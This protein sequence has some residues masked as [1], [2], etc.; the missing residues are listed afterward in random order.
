MI[1]LAVSNQKGGVGKTTTCINLAAELGRK[2]Y[3]V[4]SVDIDPQA[5][6]TS[7]LGVALPPDSPSLYNVLLGDVPPP[8]AILQTKWRGVSIL[9]ATLDLAGAEI[10]LA[11]SISRET[12][13]RR[14]LSRIEG[15]DIAIL[16]CP[17]SLGMLTVNALV[18]A[19]KLVIPIQCEYFALE[20]LGQLSRTIAL[21]KDGLNQN[22]GIDG[23]LLTMHDS[24]TRLSTDVADEVRR[25]FGDVVF[26]TFIPRNVKL[27]EAP[28][29]AEPICY[30]DPSCSGA[31]AYDEFAEEVS[32][33]WLKEED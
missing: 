23:I 2:G 28:S 32:A 26:K 10:E 16:D 15:F 13:M 14:V 8:E 3:S 24:R 31:K 29:Y 9:P 22:L 33:L 4:L 21:I 20:G 12:K 6:C 25:Q 1:T 30:Y 27:A 18:A 19:D 7:G 5:N 17:P 11:S